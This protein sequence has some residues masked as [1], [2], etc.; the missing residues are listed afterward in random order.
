MSERNMD[1]T[2]EPSDR[3][4]M[5]WASSGPL[6]RR[7]CRRRGGEQPAGHKDDVAH[8]GLPVGAQLLVAWRHLLTLPLDAGEVA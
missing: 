6:P 1:G 4:A 7:H 8:C 3:Q 5:A 2:G